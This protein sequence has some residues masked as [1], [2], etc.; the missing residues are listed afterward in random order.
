MI[1]FPGRRKLG[2]CNS[3]EGNAEGSRETLGNLEIGMGCAVLR[4]LPS[5]YHLD[6]KGGRFHLQLVYCTIVVRM[7]ECGIDPC[8]GFVPS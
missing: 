8:K 2:A 4:N 7:E 6:N 3:K 5:G 1:A